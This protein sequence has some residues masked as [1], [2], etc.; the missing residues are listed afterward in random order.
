MDQ[1]ITKLLKLHNPAIQ[2]KVRLLILEDD[3]FSDNMR[4]LQQEIRGSELVRQLLSQR[5]E[6]GRIPLDPYKKWNGA[7][8]VIN[9]IS[10]LFYP[11]GD[12]SLQPIAEQDYEWIFSD[13]RMDWVTRKTKN[14]GGNP[15]RACASM[16]GSTLFA[17]IRLGFLDERCDYLAE[18]LLAWQWPDGGW[19]CDDN[20]QAKNS[21]FMETLLPLRALSLYSRVASDPVPAHAAE[22]A[23][24]IF[25][26]RFL[27]RSQKN[28]SIME[29]N[30]LQLHYPC[31][32]H[33]D[34]LLG[35]KVMADC[36]IISD[37]RCTEALDW[38]ESRRLPDGG[39]PADAKYYHK[40]VK[41]SNASQ[42]DWGPVSSK[43]YNPY[44]T[45]DALYVLHAAGRYQAK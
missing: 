3:P 45:A 6:K 2:Y 16:E 9:T 36:G 18:R 41:E 22:R 14:A 10:D 42:V 38:L 44:V 20:P 43:K 35:L 40:R 15:T 31:Y 25:L 28:S 34:V 13:R 33:Y 17:M 27:F 30:F 7:H 37:P 19:N 26:K 29:K 5:D 23:A 21:S 8:W 1:I 12:D 4:R 32:W 24:E 11:P 39:F